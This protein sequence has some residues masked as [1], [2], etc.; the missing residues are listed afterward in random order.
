MCSP[1]T[2]K[3]VI[4]R[5]G[6]LILVSVVLLFIMI[7]SPVNLLAASLS[8]APE[9]NEDM[10]TAVSELYGITEDQALTRLA[11]ETEAA[12]TLHLIQDLSISSYAGSWFDGSTLRL[13]VALADKKDIAQI[14]RFDVDLVLVEHSLTELQEKLESAKNHLS[15][16]SG[17]NTSTV[18]SFIDYKSNTAVLEVEG[19][20]APLARSELTAFGLSESIR[21]NE[22]SGTPKVSTGPVLG[23]DG[24][25]NLTYLSEN[26]VDFPCSVGASAEGGFVTASHCDHAKNSSIGDSNHNPLGTTTIS[27][28][29]ED[30]P[31][32]DAAYVETLTGWTPTAQVNGY[33]SGNFSVSEEWA[34]MIEFPVGST[35]CRFGG[36]SGGPHCGTVNQLN[37]DQEFTLRYVPHP[38]WGWVVPVPV[39]QTILGVTRVSGSCSDDGDSGGTWVGGTGQVQGVNVGV[40]VANEGDTCPTVATWTY[41]QPI[42][43]VVDVLDVTMLTA[44]GSNAPDIT[45][46][47]CPD[48]GSSTYQRFVC[49]LTNVDSQGEVSLQWTSSNGGYSTK[50]YLQKTCT[51]NSTIS[52]TLQATNPYGTDTKNFTFPCP[53]GS[54]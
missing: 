44:H 50:R 37:L 53:D 21:I 48:I 15:L 46:V 30:N 47:D 40:S 3:Y 51:L 4:K 54:Q 17:L 45:D 28:Y 11:H 9:F 42:K 14:E 7:T 27:Q 22:I 34:G 18:T 43:D 33:T 8:T 1:I 23:G 13:K 49:W 38:T 12:I 31:F 41:F 32:I 36:T 26:G 5:N 20:Y 19:S 52:V 25:R 6:K 24:T 2:R 39:R 29:D 10:L 16:E 35:V